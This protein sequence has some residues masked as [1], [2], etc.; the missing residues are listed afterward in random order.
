MAL[1]TQHG[2]TRMR[3]RLGLPRKA[4]ARMAEKA[5]REGAQHKQ[6]SGN[7]RRY[8]DAVYLAERRAN[9]MRVYGGTLYLFDDECLITCWVLPHKFQNIRHG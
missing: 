7:F 8:L 1:V 5:L 2:E 6:F 4:V 3:K 9:N